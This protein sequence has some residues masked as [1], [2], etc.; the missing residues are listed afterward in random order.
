MNTARV[1]LHPR[2][3]DVVGDWRQRLAVLALFVLI[4]A[5]PVLATPE[6][7][8]PTVCTGDTIS[9]LQDLQPNT[10]DISTRE[11]QP[12]PTLPAP[13]RD[14]GWGDLAVISVAGALGIR[15]AR[16]RIRFDADGIVVRNPLW[17]YRIAWTDAAEVTV[18]SVGLRGYVPGIGVRRH[19][20]KRLS[21]AYGAGSLVPLKGTDYATL[22]TLIEPWALAHGTTLSFDHIDD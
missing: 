11:C 22:R 4:A 10:V 5:I 18:A 16:C 7:T 2:G 20:K 6:D 1:Q 19:G 8:R 14:V 9:P 3:V 21:R 17:T 15:R 13:K 12:D